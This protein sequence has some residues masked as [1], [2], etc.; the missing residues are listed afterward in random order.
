MAYTK[1]FDGRKF[2][3]IREM[4]A[5]V[6]VIKSADGSAMFRMGKTIAIA[7][8]RGPRNLHPRFLQN[9]EK[10]ILRCNYDLMSFSVNERKRPGPSRRSQEVSLVTEK[11]LLP[12]LNL[13]DF[14]NSVV[15]V[16]VQILQADAG[17]RCAGINAASLALADAGVPMSDLICAVAT[18]IIHKD[19]AVID[20]NK[21]E[22]DY[23]GGM[24]DTPLAIMPHSG[25]IT[26][27][28]MD[29][30]A[31]REEIK[32]AIEKTKEACMKIRDV[33]VNALKKKY[34]GIKDKF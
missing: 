31:S 13:D 5:K 6:G 25:R 21:E 23:E 7:A 26:L 8:V 11:A 33:Q 22:E 3:E 14:P 10:G 1:R 19:K 9:P 30:E 20:I 12:A 34:G 28:H 32:S 15:D 2:D 24:A 17:T 16:F 18:G 29:G 27:L 4:E